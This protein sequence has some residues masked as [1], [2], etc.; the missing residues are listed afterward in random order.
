MSC[1]RRS[2]FG[3]RSFPAASITNFTTPAIAGENSFKMVSIAAHA[4]CPSCRQRE[5]FTTSA[6]TNAGGAASFG[7]IARIFSRPLRVASGASRYTV[8]SVPS[9]EWFRLNEMLFSAFRPNACIIFSGFGASGF[10]GRPPSPDS[11]AS[12]SLMTWKLAQPN[13]SESRKS[14]L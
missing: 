5:N 14:E 10:A 9:G 13:A 4:F 7:S 6:A 11:C 1:L 8:P 2:K 12:K 3:S